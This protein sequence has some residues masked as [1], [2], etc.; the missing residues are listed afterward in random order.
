MGLIRFVSGLAQASRIP[1][2]LIIALAQFASAYMIYRHGLI[3]YIEVDILLLMVSTMMVAAGGY[4]INDYYDLKIDMI[5]RPEQVVVGKTLSRRKALVSHLLIS[6]AGIMIG[7]LFSWKIGALHIFSTFLL[8]YYSNHLRR[9]FIGKIVIASLTAFSVLAVGIGYE[10]VSY[11]LMAFATFGAAVVWVRELIK[12]LGNAKGT[13]AFGVESVHEV[14]GVR[15]TKAL[16]WT[17]TVV[18]V[19]LVVYFVIQVKTQIIAYY[20]AA[21]LPLIIWFSYKVY[22]ADRKAHFLW[23]KNFTNLLILSGLVSMLFV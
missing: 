18:A 11:R 20:Y 15:G 10:V 7:T 22:R 17:I 9:F 4:I 3:P 14:W 13:K 23:L 5:N 19:G 2:L 12:E 8:W 16:I 21:H 1:N 6:M